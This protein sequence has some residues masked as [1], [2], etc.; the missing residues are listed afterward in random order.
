MFHLYFFTT[1]IDNT[2][3]IDISG[4]KLSI[5]QVLSTFGYHNKYCAQKKHII[6]YRYH[7]SAMIDIQLDVRYQYNILFPRIVSGL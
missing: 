2:W 3:F 4:A 6:V 1:N 7:I 5:N